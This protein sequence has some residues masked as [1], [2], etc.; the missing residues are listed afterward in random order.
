MFEHTV[1]AEQSLETS[2]D[3]LDDL[4]IDHAEDNRPEFD[5]ASRDL[6]VP[7]GT[8][9]ALGQKI[10]AVADHYLRMPLRE[11][12]GTNDDKAGN[13]RKF[14]LEGLKWRPELWDHWAEKYPKSGVAK[15]EWCAAFASFCVRSAYQANDPPLK[16]P[17]TP[18]GS[19]SE[20]AGRFQAA[21]RFLTREELFDDEGAVR[22]DVKAP[23]PG[24]LVIFKGHVGVLKEIFQSGDFQTIEGNTWTG[25]IRN[26]GVY[27]CNRSSLEKRKDGGFKLVGF[28][29]LASVDGQ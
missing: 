14:F 11:D 10:V 23:G 19:A 9:T 5:S 3:I 6:L 8:D 13:L 7:V 18:S 29:L 17:A 24:D 22:A 27:A 28:C 2:R 15:P 21:G 4:T 1:D 16:L 20:M 12:A 26:D 25:K